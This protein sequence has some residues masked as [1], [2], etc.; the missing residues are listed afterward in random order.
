M[1]TRLDKYGE[2]YRRLRAAIRFVTGDTRSDPR[3]FSDNIG[4]FLQLVGR[5]V[6]E[7][8]LWLKHGMLEVSVPEP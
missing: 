7:G 5:P 6:P 3:W 1:F 4:D 2:D 8:K